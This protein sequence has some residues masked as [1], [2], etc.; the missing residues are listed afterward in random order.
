MMSH[1][2]TS[3]LRLATYNIHSGI[4][5]DGRRDLARTAQVIAE[6]AADVVA[7]QEVDSRHAVADTLTFLAG[8]TGM[9]ALA[10][11][12]LQRKDSTYGNA[13]LTGKSVLAVQRIDLSVPRCEP[14]G[15]LD[16]HIAV[17]GLSVRVIATHLGLR[18]AERR[19]QIAT[20]LALLECRPAPLTVLMGDLNEWL[21]WGRPLRRLRAHFG[22]APAPP[23]FP[24]RWPVFALDRIWV[25]PRDRLQRVAVHDSKLAR[26]A[27]D[28]L[29]LL[30]DVAIG[31]SVV[32][33]GGT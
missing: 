26:Q 14:R 10:G 15:A 32:V 11:P 2:A 8:Q 6:L 16:I 25:Q 31:P 3:P 29:P 24:A 4:G 7:L 23:T 1:A 19:T 33:P 28:H 17:R 21:L 20:L 5:R 27:S 9:T 13:V 22:H 12:T 30:A 18:P